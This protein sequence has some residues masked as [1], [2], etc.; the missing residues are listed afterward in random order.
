MQRLHLW[1]T[2]AATIAALFAATA[3]SPATARQRHHHHHWRGHDTVGSIY[4]SGHGYGRN[5]VTGRRLHKC[6]MDLGYGRT[7]PCDRGGNR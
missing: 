2:I 4:N 7:E 1:L 3:L 5:R 6:T